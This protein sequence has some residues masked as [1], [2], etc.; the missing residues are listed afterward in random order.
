[1]IFSVGAFAKCELF[2]LSD[3]FAIFFRERARRDEQNGIL[4]CPLSLENLKDLASSSFNSTWSQ[5]GQVCEINNS[6]YQVLI[7]VKS[8]PG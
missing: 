2:D 1:M 8:C 7:S 4:K 5:R 6:A 3:S